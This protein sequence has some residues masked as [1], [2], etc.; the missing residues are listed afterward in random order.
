MSWDVLILHLPEGVRSV[1]EL[2]DD[3]ESGPLGDRTSLIGAIH[4]VAP[5]VDFSDPAWGLLSRDAFSIEFNVGADEQVESIM[6]HVRGGAGSVELIAE[7]LARLGERAVDVQT[8][9]LFEP[10]AAVESLAEWRAYRD[11]VVDPTN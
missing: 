8:G 1:S 9:D 2:P 11:Q 5:D 3:F 4:A 10:V 6:L 7:L